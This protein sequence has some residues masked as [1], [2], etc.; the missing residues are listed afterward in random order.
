[1]KKHRKKSA[2]SRTGDLI[3]QAEA[4]RIRGVSRQAIGSLVKSGRFRVRRVGGKPLLHRK[5]VEGFVP[6]G[7]PQRLAYLIEHFGKHPKP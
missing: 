1:M 5:E 7:G 4:A 2:K 6:W 3:T